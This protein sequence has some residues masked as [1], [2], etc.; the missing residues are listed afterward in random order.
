MSVKTWSAVEKYITELLVPPDAAL[1]E[2]LKASDAAGLA[3]INVTP[4]EGRLLWILAKSI[5]ARSILE[6]GTLGGYSTIWLARALPP[7]G[8]LI[9][10]EA[11][12]KHAEIARANI[13][14]AGLA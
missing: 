10:L 9:T 4:N 3:P 7:D 14:R 5:G 12:P 13:E 6:I 8:R 2:A 1:T 11:D